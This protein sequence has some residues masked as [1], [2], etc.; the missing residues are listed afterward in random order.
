[1]VRFDADA[2]AD[3]GATVAARV[4]LPPEPQ[5]ERVLH[6][7]V[8]RRRLY[9]SRD[10]RFAAVVND[11]GRHGQVVDLDSGEVTLSLDGGFRHA[12]TVPFSFA[13]T[14]EGGRTLAVHRTGWN[15]LD[16]SDALSGELLTARDPGHRL[17]YFHGA[18]SVSPQGTRIADDGWVWHPLGVPSVWNLRSWA[19][20]VSR[21]VV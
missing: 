9:V 10:G 19:G 18:L 21:E 2:D 3:A 17:D 11:F 1:M 6:G 14:E 5:Q 4:D 8:V 16:L 15:R 7:Q 12:Y 13:F 20:V